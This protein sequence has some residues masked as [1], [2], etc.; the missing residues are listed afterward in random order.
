MTSKRKDF[1]KS[2]KCGSNPSISSSFFPSNDKSS[3]SKFTD[4]EKDNLDRYKDDGHFRVAPFNRCQEK[5]YVCNLKFENSKYIN[6]NTLN[7]SDFYSQIPIYKPLCFTSFVVLSKDSLS[8]CE[9]EDVWLRYEEYLTGFHGDQI[10]V[11]FEKRR[12][13]PNF[14]DQFHPVSISYKGRLRADYVNKAYENFVEDYK[15]DK[16]KTADPTC[17]GPEALDVEQLYDENLRKFINL[18]SGGEDCVQTYASF[19]SSNSTNILADIKI[20]C[21]LMVSL[22][23]ERNIVDNPILK[24]DLNKTLNHERNL[25]N[26]LQNFDSIKSKPINTRGLEFDKCKLLDLTLTYLWRVHGIDYYGLRDLGAYDRSKNMRAIRSDETEKEINFIKMEFTAKEIIKTWKKRISTGDDID[27]LANKDLI[28]Q[29]LDEFIYRH[30]KKE[31]DTVW[32]CMLPPLDPTAKKCK[33]F[34]SPDFVVM[35]IKAK[36]ETEVT[37]V[38]KK[39]EDHFYKENYKNA[40]KENAFKNMESK[41]LDLSQQRLKEDFSMKFPKH[42]FKPYAQL[43]PNHIRNKK[44]ISV[45]TSTKK[46]PMGKSSGYSEKSKTEYFDLDRGENNKELLNYYD[47]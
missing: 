24:S 16:V 40:K 34:Q 30:I 17:D 31:S 15:L 41:K 38:R 23:N 13:E 3:L 22:D 18:P 7:K 5:S 10:L 45:H 20:S 21:N 43:I 25:S 46:M 26:G 9:P 29:Y 4:T 11:E 32:A 47:F 39:I 12:D 27:K 6:K 35:H 36:H 28:A 8:K 1:D 19:E 42:S 14:R 37:R 44:P 2:R 33:I